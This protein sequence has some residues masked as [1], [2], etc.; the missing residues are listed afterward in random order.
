MNRARILTTSALLV[1]AGSVAH[2]QG[3]RGR[4]RGRGNEDKKN[5]P[6]QEQQQRVEEQRR[7]DAAYQETLNNQVRAAQ[8]AAAALQEQR[9]MAQYNLNQQ[10]LANL[11]QQQERLRTQ[12]DVQ[13]DPY[14]ATPMNYRY[15]IAG[16]DR[17][18]NQYGADLLR[19]AVNS[20]Y[21]QGWKAGRADRSDRWSSNYRKS[22]A[23]QDANYGYNG[24]Y[25]PQSDYNYYFRQGFRR[26]YE[27]GYSSRSQYG[28]V[29][30]GSPSIL[31]AILSGILGLQTMH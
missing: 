10:Y 7:R 12:R 3:D 9:R 11:Q 21:Q 4:G 24:N 13:R 28:T 31:S 17:E 5:V 16:R 8:Q 6:A 22:Y 14:Y 1:L 27:D 29:A 2:A 30:N 23:Y 18:T 25:I 26:G 20:G 15:R 19:E